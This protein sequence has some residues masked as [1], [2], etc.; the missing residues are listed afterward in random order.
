MA[1]DE[2]PN[3]DGKTYIVVG[4]TSGIGKATV[5]RLANCG[6]RIVMASR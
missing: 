2:Y 4:S 5:E 6:A 1:V 3:L